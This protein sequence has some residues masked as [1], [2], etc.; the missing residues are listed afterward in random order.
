L[1]ILENIVAEFLIEEE[2]L[3]SLC[4]ELVLE[5]A[6]DMSLDRNRMNK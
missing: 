2:A 1:Y 5:G 6:M 4:G 3:D